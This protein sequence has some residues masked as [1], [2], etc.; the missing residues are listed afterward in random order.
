LTD[1]AP[2][3]ERS[4]T[5]FTLSDEWLITREGVGEVLAGCR[6]STMIDARPAAFW[7]GKKKHAA[8]SRSGTLEG[9]LQITHDSWFPGSKSR[10]T[11]AG[12]V[13]E[14]ARETGYAPNGQELVS[15]CNTGHWA[16]TNWFAM[17]ELAGI[18]GVKL[19]P[20]S[21]VGWSNASGA[22]V[23]GGRVTSGSGPRY[24]AMAGWRAPHGAAPARGRGL[25]PCQPFLLLRQP[26]TG[27]FGGF[28]GRSGPQTWL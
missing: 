25:S 9:S 4:T 12:R 22:L 11:A 17:S 18:E 1:N 10:L 7:E 8:A 26:W 28:S 16:A 5:S 3:P 13:L 23:N 15:F 24:P 6:E 19:Y 27:I 20:E 2:A 21:L 14:I